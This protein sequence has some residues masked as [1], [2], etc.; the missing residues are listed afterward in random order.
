MRWKPPARYTLVSYE[1]DSYG[2]TE[3]V[4]GAV[5]F[6]EPNPDYRRQKMVSFFEGV[7]DTHCGEGLYGAWE[8]LGR[9]L[10]GAEKDL[11]QDVPRCG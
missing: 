10:G 1:F 6:A 4:L 5:E 9:A 2:L 3:D 8:A 7:W 11:E